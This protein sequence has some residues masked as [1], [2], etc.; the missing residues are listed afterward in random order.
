MYPYTLLHL[1]L[2]SSKSSKEELGEA[3]PSWL[4]GR[5]IGVYYFLKH[6]P[7]STDVFSPSNPLLLLTG[8]LTGVPGIPA[9]GRSVSITLSPKNKRLTYSVGGGNFGP[10][11]RFNGIDGIVLEGRAEEPVVVVVEGGD[12]YIESAEGLWGKDVYETDRILRERYGNDISTVIIGPVGERTN[13]NASIMIDR[14]SAMGRGGHGAVMGYKRVKAIVVKKGDKTPLVHDI[15]AFRSSFTEA[16][17]EVN[18][19]EVTRELREMGTLGMLVKRLARDNMLPAY[20]FARYEYVDRERLLNDW[21][22]YI[23]REK[24]VKV[25]CWQCMIACKKYIETKA[26]RG[27][28]PEYWG[29]FLSL[30]LSFGRTDIETVAK[31]YERANR[32]G[33]DAIS[34]GHIAR[35]LSEAFGMEEEDALDMVLKGEYD[36][37]TR[38]ISEVSSKDVDISVRDFENGVCDPRGSQGYALGVA[39]NNRGD[40]NQTMLRDEVLYER[41]DPRSTEGKAEYVYHRQNLFL[42]ADSMVVCIFTTYSLDYYHYGKLYHAVTGYDVDM[43]K[44][45]NLIYSAERYYNYLRGLEP[46]DGLPARLKR[47]IDL[48][49]ML[50]EYY[51]LRGWENGVPSPG[52]VEEIKRML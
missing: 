6:V 14:D 26:Y 49:K 40:E 11:L 34:W 5:G 19:D 4:G 1:D 18:A 27:H 3:L 23:N 8:P 37:G 28:A 25:K 15:T 12:V 7:P 51:A 38:Y 46:A 33:I 52:L 2:S 36:R 35:A 48:E 42:I 16:V 22:G 47:G 39:T 41:R 20:N 17:R 31:R 9:A 44:V 32:E 45:S 29:G 13:R 50:P 30:G 43:E 21:K 24:S 10:Y